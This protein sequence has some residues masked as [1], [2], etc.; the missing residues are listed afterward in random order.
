MPSQSAKAVNYAFG[1]LLPRQNGITA[2][3]E[4]VNLQPSVAATSFVAGVVVANVTSSAN[5]VQTVTETGTPSGGTFTLAGYNPLTSLNVTAAGILQAST[6]AQLQTIL[7]ATAVFGAGN[8]TVSGSGGG[9]FTLTF[10][11]ALAAMPV[12]AMT[13]AVNSFTGGSS[14]SVTIAHTTVGRTGGTYGVYNSA[15]AAAPTIPTV[16]GTGSGSAF[17]AGT[18]LVTITGV[19]A[20]GETTAAPPA[21]VTLTSAQKIRVAA[22]TGLDTS[23][24]ALNV[25]VDGTFVGTAAVSAGTSTQTDVDVATLT[26]AGKSVPLSNTAYTIPNGAGT[27]TAVGLLIY[28][29]QTDAAG[30]ISYSSSSA[31]GEWGQTDA[32]AAIYVSGTFDV[33]QIT[34][35]DAKAVRDLG[36][37]R[38]GTT[39][40]G[41][42]QLI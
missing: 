36:R 5:D 42:L 17:A 41:E 3:T 8:V 18:H 34:G 26:A 33:S 21:P 37:L 28:Q 29:C 6:A 19:N 22:L 20:Q 25:Y 4:L 2:Q 23:F 38:W 14:P 35:L 1:P 27:Q 7:Q 39:T 32:A 13:L 31:T 15:V 11:G 40:V 10:T 16:S 30:Q 12:P 24:T 9:P